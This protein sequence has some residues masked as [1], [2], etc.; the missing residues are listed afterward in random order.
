MANRNLQEI[1]KFEDNW[2]YVYFEKGH[3]E[4]DLKSV[5]YTFL[6]KKI[7]VPVETLSLMMLGP[8][9]TITH[10]A[11]KRIADSRCLLAWVGEEGVKF[12]SSGYTGTHSS[13]NLLRQA[14]AFSDSE[15][16]LK[17]VHRMYEKRF[18]ES[19][20]PKL[21]IEQ[22]RGKEG[23]RVRK[24]YQ[25]AAELYGIKWTGRNYDQSE[26]LFGDPV[27]RALSSVNSCLYGIC[28]TAIL[29]VGCS[30]GIGF[31]HT[32]KQLS[33]VYDIADLY[34]TEIAI[35]I[36]FEAAKAETSVESKARFLLRDKLKETRLIKRIIPD[37][38]EILY[39][40]RDFRELFT[41]PEG[42]DVA[43]NS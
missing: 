10:E 6:D 20:G 33:F 2:T 36:A 42:R 11:I 17:V 38:M 41:E 24:S 12:Y 26:W 40:D 32:G 15:E 43:I 30:A 9:T 37:I 29:A 18:G 14:T 16:R 8:G 5:A 3:I 7:P 39:G 1:P 34:K 19:L 25:E 4:Q 13:R 21:S 23:A 35:P 31:I 22:L 28:Q 27:N